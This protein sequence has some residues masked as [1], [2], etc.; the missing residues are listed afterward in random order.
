MHPSKTPILM[1][2]KSSEEA[3]SRALEIASGNHMTTI[4]LSHSIER[5]YPISNHIETVLPTP[6]SFVTVNGTYES[7]NGEVDVTLRSRGYV[8][9]TWSV[10]L[11]YETSRTRTMFSSGD[12]SCKR[13]RSLG[14]SAEFHDGWL[15]FKKDNEL[16]SGDC[17]ILEMIKEPAANDEKLVFELVHVF[18][19][20]TTTLPSE[21]WKRPR[22]HENEETVNVK[23]K[24]S[25]QHNEADLFSAE[26]YDSLVEIC[27]EK[28]E[29]VSE[30]ECQL[31]ECEGKQ[32]GDE[33][34]LG[35]RTM[36]AEAVEDLNKFRIHTSAV[37]NFC[38][39]KR[40]RLQKLFADEKKIQM[41]KSKIMARFEDHLRSI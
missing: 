11:K 32:L 21:K 3:A 26:V 1:E 30:L 22:D 17:I 25:D 38:K 31:A 39:D 7:G 40:Q 20:P 9:R 6:V 18:R 37:L 16:I 36:H 28:E 8:D 29:V 33:N 34:I 35:L 19:P 12:W 4:I 13:R 2:V 10:S 24:N 41:E 15:D 27:K 14:T 5:F 23:H